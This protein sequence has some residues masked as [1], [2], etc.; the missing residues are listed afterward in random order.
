[1]SADSAIAPP[2]PARAAV[3]YRLRGGA[4]EVSVDEQDFLGST[5]QGLEGRWQ[6]QDAVEHGLIQ[7]MALI[8]LKLLRLDTIELRQL[9]AEIAEPDARRL[10]A[11][12]TLARYR[13]RLLKERW[14]AEYRLRA[15]IA[16]RGTNEAE[17]TAPARNRQIATAAATGTQP[18]T[19]RA[20]GDGDG[21]G[22]SLNRG[23]RRRLAA[24]KRKAA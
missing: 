12:D 5:L 6:P 24:L 20:D 3:V 10:P 18:G 4:I 7:T 22:R 11:L 15:A 14:Q 1:M 13:T 16:Q 17:P 2:A 21:D 9:D 8:D 23:Q 19:G